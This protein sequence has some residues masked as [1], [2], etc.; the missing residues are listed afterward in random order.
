MKQLVIL[1]TLV[2]CFAGAR[3]QN[4]G[5][6]TST[7]AAL[8]DVSATNNGILIPR[9]ALTGTNSASP[10]SAPVAS[11]LVYNNAT[12]G[13][14]GTAV[15]PGFYYWYSSAWVRVIDANSSSGPTTNTLLLSG[16]TLTSDVNG[17]APT[18]SLSGLTLS[19]DVTGTLG[20]SSVAGIQGT[21]V[22]ISSLTTSNLLQYNGTNW[23]NV[24]PASVLS[25][26]TTHTLSLTGNTLTSTVNGI[27]PTQSLSGL[28]ISGDVTGTLA[29]S[30]VAGIQGTGVAIS[31]LTTSNLL[32]YNG[33]SWINVTPA[34]VAVNIYNAD[35]TLTG[36]RTMTMGADNLT[37][38]STTGNLI[39]N[40]SSTGKVG[41]GTPAPG[42]ALDVNGGIHM[43]GTTTATTGTLRWNSS[44]NDFEGYDGGLWMSHS[45]LLDRTMNY[46]DD[47]F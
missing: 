8:L 18:Q 10:L 39:F 19:G 7:P 44:T 15:S 40:P 23:V 1:F 31:S 5:I 33:T 36:N 32:Q 38:S 45:G 11:T 14:G 17:V 47:G 34:S 12:A 4:V 43:G 25:A 24:T 35:G 22:A 6:G 13:S 28:S 41:I 46:T 27:A 29:S 30:T 9:V 3:A 37:F 20:A 2:F 26:A 21:G 16:N 42:Q